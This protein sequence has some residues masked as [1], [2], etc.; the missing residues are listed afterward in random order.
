MQNSATNKRG[1]ILVFSVLLIGVIGIFLSI[2]IGTL[3]MDNRALSR[4]TSQSLDL[5]I[6]E[7]GIDRAIFCLNHA[8]APLCTVNYS[9]ET[10]S[11]GAGSFSVVVVPQGLNKKITSTGTVNGLARTIEVTATTSPVNA[12]FFYG[13]QAGIGGITMENNNT[14]TGNIYANGSVIGD[15]NSN[16]TGDVILAAGD[17]TTD[18]AADPY[19]SNYTTKILGQ[20]T[21]Q[22]L[23]QSFVPTVTDKV[24]EIDLKLART[25]S[26]PSDM[27]LMIYSDSG[28]NPGSLVTGA[29]MTISAGTPPV[30][31]P[32]T[33]ENGWT[34]IIF[35]PQTILSAGTRYW[36]VIK[37]SSNN[38]SRYYTVLHGNNDDGF[39][40]DGTAKFGTSPTTGLTALCSS[41]CD[42][43][44]QVKMGGVAPLLRVAGRSGGAGVGGNAYANTIE[45]TKIG[46]HA[47]YQNLDDTVLA[48]AASAETCSSS[49]AGAT[50]CDV[51]NTK[52]NIPSNGSYCHPN[53]PDPAPAP[54]PLTSAQIVQM[55]S[56]GTAGGV[57]NCS[58]PCTISSG[59][60]GP[61]KYVGDVT[62][63]GSVTLAGTV[64]VQG[65]LTLDGTITLS[66]GYG[67][68]S[69][70]LI[71]DKASDPTNSGRII[72]TNNAEVN[73]N[74]QPG[75]YI[76]LLAVS[77]SFADA[78]PAIDI[79]NS[80]TA[81]VIYAANGAA[82]MKNSANLKEATAQKM[83]MKNGADVTYES[84]LASA[85][86]TGGPGGS[87]T[88]LPQTWREVK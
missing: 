11:I 88:I 57:T 51:N 58:S 15:N 48:H 8:S 14:I 52:P 42:A 40:A 78:A 49:G 53:N 71:A 55:E 47:C 68:S 24:Y 7:A 76:M 46:Q 80:L 18:A 38:S 83:I 56:Q 70:V 73:G 35:T 69:G 20:N 39:Y 87:W 21:T 27:N 6:A 65:N 3:V 43:A 77:N 32:G 19:P 84:G 4:E 37:L 72:I 22:Y 64:W 86:F 66:N 31:T 54:F 59:T 16:V 33:W 9:G 62:I 41:G 85:V 63:S 61:R 26:A 30:N 82:I 67:A 29:Q 74:G 13:L 44:F 17:P 25:S 36:I 81:G 10:Q 50:P 23:V 75:T 79:N 1:Q 60:A 12:S 5:Q 28:G 2:L 34:E 45:E